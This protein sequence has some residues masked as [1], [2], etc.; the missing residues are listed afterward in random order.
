MRDAARA[1]RLALEAPEQLLAEAMGGQQYGQAAGGHLVLN[2]V[3]ATSISPRP[4]VELLTEFYADAPVQAA[5]LPRPGAPD[6]RRAGGQDA[7]L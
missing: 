1:L 3:A 4:T 7:W 6:H 2:V 5:R